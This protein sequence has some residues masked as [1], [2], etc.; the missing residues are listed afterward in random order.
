MVTYSHLFSRNI[1]IIADR[2]T[3][4]WGSLRIKNETSSA[5]IKFIISI[6]NKIS[7]ST[8]FV[9]RKRRANLMSYIENHE[10]IYSLELSMANLVFEDTSLLFHDVSSDI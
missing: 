4:N 7:V 2:P 1:D 3:K 8:E 10:I 6:H 9:Q 5:G